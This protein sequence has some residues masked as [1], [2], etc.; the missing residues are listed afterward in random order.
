M[1]TN[2]SCISVYR[3]GETELV[4]GLAVGCQQLRLRDK[5]R[6]YRYRVASGPRQT[7]CNLLN[8]SRPRFTFSRMSFAVAVQMNGLGL[9][10]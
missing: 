3:Y 4:P 10:L 6:V 7:V 9:L 2:D 1:G 5:K 8:F